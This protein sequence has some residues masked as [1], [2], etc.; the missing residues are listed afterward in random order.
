MHYLLVL[1]AALTFFAQNTLGVTSTASPEPQIVSTN[2]DKYIYP[3]SNVL[4]M[5]TN[6]LSLSS[7]DDPSVVTDWY[8]ELLENNFNIKNV[9]R[10]RVN[11][12][13]EN[14]LSASS[15]SENVTID[16]TSSGAGT[17]V[18]VSLNG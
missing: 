6:T 11:G 18:K 12:V 8:K 9:V 7:D 17:T 14:K 2:L 15:D 16:I 3:N 13:V 4:E 5:T 10:T 1:I